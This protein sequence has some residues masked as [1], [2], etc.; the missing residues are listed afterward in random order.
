M[1]QMALTEARFDCF[2]GFL[3]KR[4]TNPNNSGTCSALWEG[5]DL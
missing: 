2:E 3:G 1:S 5:Y 4:D